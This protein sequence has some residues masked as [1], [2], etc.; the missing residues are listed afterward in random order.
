MSFTTRS[1]R[2]SK[3]IWPIKMH[4]VC[5]SPYLDLEIKKQKVEIGKVKAKSTNKTREQMHKT[6]EQMQ[7]L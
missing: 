3:T 5:F 1:S 2:T 7:T 4:Y 6:R